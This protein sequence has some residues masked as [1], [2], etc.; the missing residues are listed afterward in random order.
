M[1]SV[2]SVNTLSCIQH[3][4]GA[5][6]GCNTTPKLECHP[7]AFKERAF[8]NRK[9]RDEEW[10]KFST[11]YTGDCLQSPSL[12]SSGT[13]ALL[14][15]VQRSGSYN[16][17][18]IEFQTSFPD[19][20]NNSA[21]THCQKSKTKRKKKCYSLTRINERIVLLDFIHRL[22]SQKTNRI[23]E[24]KIYTKYHNTHVHK[25]HTRINY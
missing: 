2:W 4:R 16:P 6:G 5:G 11:S 8:N 21:H 23:E 18:R 25:I 24:L 1:R 7:T 10:N 15:Y 9:W 13:T 14:Y 17:L 20:M 3:W 22:V 19:R 12:H